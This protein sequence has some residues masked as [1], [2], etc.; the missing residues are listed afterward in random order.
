MHVSIHPACIKQLLMCT[1][2]G[3]SS[4][5][6]DEDMV[7]ISYARQ[8]VRDDDGRACLHHFSQAL[9]NRVLR[10]RIDTCQCVIENE[11]ARFP[12]DGA[13]ESCALPLAA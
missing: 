7:R 4:F 5:V 12:H 9:E 13:C 2:F 3:D 10:V 8:A 1:L 11:Y 6:E